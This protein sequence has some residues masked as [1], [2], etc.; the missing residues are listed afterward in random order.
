MP[1]LLVRL[2]VILRLIG[3]LA[4]A[5]SGSSIL[6]VLL[7]VEDNLFQRIAIHNGAVCSGF[8]IV[9]YMIGTAVKKKQCSLKNTTKIKSYKESEKEYGRYRYID[10]TNPR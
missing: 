4:F 5:V 6:F 2:S 7:T 3:L 1:V 9:L 8:G 10:T